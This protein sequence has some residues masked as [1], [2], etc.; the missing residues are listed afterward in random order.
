MTSAEWA[1]AV[2][3]GAPRQRVGYVRVVIQL[4]GSLSNSGIYRANNRIEAGAAMNE[5][6]TIAHDTLEEVLTEIR[7]AL[8]E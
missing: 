7:M 3:E 2:N 8:D 4:D 5:V 6:T 1:D